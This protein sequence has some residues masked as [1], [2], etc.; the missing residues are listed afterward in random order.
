MTPI[1]ALLALASTPIQ[2]SP[3]QPLYRFIAYGDTRGR[4]KID[5]DMTVQKEV[6][7]G[8]LAAHPK[9][10][11]QSGDLVN[12][13]S[14]K[15]LWDQ[16]DQIMRP[17]WNAKIAYY[18]AEGN[19]DNMGTTN[20]H[21]YLKSRIMP[22][23]GKVR[24]GYELETYSV[25]EKPLRFI[26]VNTEDPTTEGSKQYKWLKHELADAQKHHLFAVP[27]FH[28]TI[29]SIGDHGSDTKK[30][31]Q[32]E[33]LFMK[34]HVP[35]VIMGHDHI[36]YRTRRHGIV[37]ITTG[38]GGAPLYDLHADRDPRAADDPADPNWPD[39]SQ[40]AFHYCVCDVYKDHID[41]VV[42]AVH[43]DGPNPIDKFSIP[44][45]R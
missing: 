32:L 37:Y 34:Y 8:A 24:K 16:F 14:I 1:L 22:G 43:F 28:I 26:A 40:K 27:M 10:I 7:A 4:T 44:L 31:A 36:Y 42:Q 35:L 21:D 20:Y 39:V 45:S 23:W 5:T 12:D 2:M 11:V 19:H 33:P 9:F 13:S 6:I 3:Q 18:P 41:V 38:G 25:D 30:Q 17:V 15:P 29:H